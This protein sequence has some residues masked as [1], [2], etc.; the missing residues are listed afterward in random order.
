MTAGC[1]AF[2]RVV[3]ATLAVAF[4]SPAVAVGQGTAVAPPPPAASAPPADGSHLQVYV[5]TMGQGDYVWEKFG[6]NAL[7]IRDLRTGEDLVYNWGMF[8]FD[9]AGF[10]PRFLRGEMLYW[11]DAADARLTLLAYQRMNRSVTVQELQLAPAQ[12]LALQEFVQWNIRPENA[13]YRYDYYR[14]NCS[15]RV[16]DALDRVLGGAIRR[17]AAR[18]PTEMTY[19]DHSLRLLHDLFWSRTGVDLALGAPTDRRITRWE[20][21]FVP[22]E[23]Q[24]VLRELRVRDESGN[25]VPLVADERVLFEAT[26]PPARVRPDVPVTTFLAAGLALATLLVAWGYRT[27]G[28]VPSI[29]VTVTWGLLAGLLGTLVLLLWVATQHVAAHRNL[30]L[31]LANPLWLALAFLVPFVNAGRGT[32]KVILFVA[33]SAAVLTG[34]AAVLALTPWGQPSGAI[35][36]FFVPMNL[37]VYLLTLR[38]IYLA[39][40]RARRA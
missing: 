35:P 12:R 37:G 11:M 26:R 23:L 9:Q 21:S 8:S 36:A 39:Q 29:T 24:A 34:V 40:E 5:M 15:T 38:A 3:L 30:N 14:D 28:P 22:M 10:L 17:Q 31:L 4:T 25:L 27:R 32:R 18:Q 6:H 33:R 19:R 20:A 2:S 16:R 1:A 13:F 7:G